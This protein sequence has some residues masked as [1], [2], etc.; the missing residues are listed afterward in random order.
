MDVQAI[1][2]GMLFDADTARVVAKTLGSHYA[3]SGMPP[4]V[5]DPVCVS[6]SGHSLLQPQA[7]EI[8]IKDLFPLT[9]LITPNKSEAELLLSHQNLPC[10]IENLEDMLSA[11]KNLLTLEPGAVLLKG[12]HIMVT[13]AEVKRTCTNFP[14]IQV[15][16]DGVLDENMEI[17][18][19]S[20]KDPSAMN[21]VVDVL[22]ER[23]GEAYVICSTADRFDEHTW[24]RM[25]A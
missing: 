4:L 19:V 23:E 25:Y 15:I 12:G 7:I 16:N 17:L 8:M 9:T 21:L 18:R 10:K 3:K 5:C 24:H 1:K 2:T 6:T 11:A 20:E 22:Y 14:Y 13:R